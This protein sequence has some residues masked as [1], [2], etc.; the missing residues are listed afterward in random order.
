MNR[1]CTA[2]FNFK[3]K[4]KRKANLWEEMLDEKRGSHYGKVRAQQ[5]NLCIYHPIKLGFE[6][7][8]VQ[9]KQFVRWVCCSLCAA[10]L[11]SLPKW[12]YKD[13]FVQNKH[14]EK[15]KMLCLIMAL[16]NLKPLWM[17]SETSQ[18]FVHF[19][20][21]AGSQLFYLNLE[22]GQPNV[23]P[24]GCCGFFPSGRKQFGITW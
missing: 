17:L 19:L 2:S 9:P 21:S 8:V 4:K 20:E 23:A 24:P 1:E 18:P 16:S 11:N 5:R 10:P 6:W 12:D 7:V 13:I 15:Y 14:S 3:K 22:L